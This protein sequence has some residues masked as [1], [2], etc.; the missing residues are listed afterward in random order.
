MSDEDFQLDTEYDFSDDVSLEPDQ[1]NVG[2]NKQDWLKFQSKGQ[3]IR[4]AFVY[5]Y[6]HDANAVLRATREARKKLPKEEQVKLAKAALTARAEGLGKTIDKLT[7]AEKLDPSVA[8]FKLL[9]AHY[10]PDHQVGYVISRLGKDGPEADAIWKRLPE[11]KTY[12]ITLLLIYPTDTEGTLQKETFASQYKNN[13]FRL[14][15]W[16]FSSKVHDTIWKLND[17]LRADE[18][19]I[20][21]KDLK[22]ECD[23][24]QFQSVTI[25]SAGNAAWQKNPQI[26][27]AVLTQ[28]AGMYDKLNPFREM[29][30]E[31][32][33]AKLGISSGGGSSADEVSSGD[34]QD[35]LDSV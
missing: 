11:P 2:G 16:R 26:A 3:I 30:T 10:E 34:F 23:N 5:F 29:T 12:F 6:T 35:M 7:L 31:Q 25:Q 22:I 15:P 27:E 19:S 13:K 24:P 21:M 4:G 32:L 28:A 33:K 17:G 8:H 1:K 9:K 18:S 20:A 14:V